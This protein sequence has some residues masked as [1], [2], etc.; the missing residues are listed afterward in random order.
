MGGD[1]L[2][3]FGFVGFFDRGDFDTRMLKEDVQEDWGE[4]SMGKQ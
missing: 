2:C 4:D 1:L 3:C